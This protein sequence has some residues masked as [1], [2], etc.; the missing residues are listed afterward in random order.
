M[1][2]AYRLA[3]LV[4]LALAMTP[5]ACSSDGG[6]T[7]TEPEPVP[8]DNA[9][10]EFTHEGTLTLVPGETTQVGIV[11]DPPDYYEVAFY[12][13]GAALDASLDPSML[14]TDQDGRGL[15]TLRAPNEATS[16]VLRAAI[17]DGQAAD[18]PVAVSAEGFGA[19]DITPRYT[20]QRSTE[21]WVAKVVSGT[22]C[23]ELAASLPE[24][25]PGA[26]SAVA[27]P[28]EPL[29]IDVAPVGPNLAIMVRGGHYMWGC[30]DEAHLVAGETTRVEVPVVNAPVDTTHALLDVQMTF[31]PDAGAWQQLVSASTEQMVSAMFGEHGLEADALLCA[32]EAASPDPAAF[33]AHAAAAEWSSLVTGYL[34]A[35]PLSLTDTVRALASA[36]VAA[37]PNEL[38][39]RLAG[40]EEAPGFGVFSLGR[41]GTVSPDEAGVPAEYLLTLAVD[42]ADAVQLGGRLFWLASRWVAVAADAAATTANAEHDGV[43]AALAEQMRCPELANTLG[44]L[45]D[46]DVACMTELCRAGLGA[47]W[48]AAA[49]SSATAGQVGELTL[50]ASG[51]A[52]FDDYASLEGFEGIWLGSIS[53]GTTEASLTGEATA[54]PA[55]NAQTP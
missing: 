37:Q 5:A 20:G 41:I 6:R 9:T 44:E 31:V 30:T 4:A 10:I 21:L 50:Q 49:S 54:K 55:E 33:A 8:G 35:E 43:A 15:V 25:P 3:T 17:T 52:Q 16:F 53:D 29:V 1:H 18:L 46:C 7:E 34:D 47:L 40:L 28:G 14:V 12:L 27:E 2:L 45:P 13:V 22:T 51:P 19:L 39:G 38:M 42:P 26:L 24:D 11:T 23:A 48:T 36:G 32:M